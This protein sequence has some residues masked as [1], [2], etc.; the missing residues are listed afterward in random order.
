MRS[1]LIGSPEWVA[2][3]GGALGV[4]DQVRFGAQAVRQELRPRPRGAG[5]VLDAGRLPPS[6]IVAQRIDEYARTTLPDPLLEH[7]VRSWLWGCLLA[8]LDR[9]EYDE[10]RLYVAALLHDVGLVNRPGPDAACFAV[11]G[12]RVA[13]GVVSDAGGSED[14][15]T[16]VAD[17]IAAHFNVEV[18]LSWGPEAHLLHAGTHLDVVGRR[19]SELARSTVAD[20]HA[21]APRTD[22]PDHFRT[23]VREEATQRPKSRAA[24]LW[25]LGMQRSI[26]RFHNGAW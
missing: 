2:R 16:V 23:V 17:A 20:V 12:A 13:R 8:E 6:S 9:I 15:A 4:W 18:P 3:T 26:H 1:G 11:H 22:F 19:I 10:E 25:R 7:S 5:A 14:F 21:Q 24:V